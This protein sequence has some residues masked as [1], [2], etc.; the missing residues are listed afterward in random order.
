MKSCRPV[1]SDNR[2]IIWPAAIIVSV[3]IVYIEK[4]SPRLLLSDDSLSHDSMTM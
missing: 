3:I 1:G 4:I 2:V